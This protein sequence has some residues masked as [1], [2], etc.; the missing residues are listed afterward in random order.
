MFA[1]VSLRQHLPVLMLDGLNASVAAMARF[2][3]KGISANPTPG[4]E[5]GRC[6]ATDLAGARG[7]SGAPAGLAAVPPTPTFQDF[8]PATHFM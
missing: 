6:D 3:G 4:G 2:F 1:P 7:W 5:G 8:N